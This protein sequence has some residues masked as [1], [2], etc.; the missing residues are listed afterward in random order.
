MAVPA[1]M[2]ALKPYLQHAKQTSKVDPLMSYH[3]EHISPARVLTSLTS[4]LHSGKYYAAT[5]GID[6]AP[7]QPDEK[8]FLLS[9][10]D[11]LDEE[12]K[13]LREQLG[14]PANKAPHVRQ[15]CDKIFDK[16]DAEDRAGNASK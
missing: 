3:C 11:E 9:I 16:A 12:K 4:K 13:V 14:D 5:L 2:K 7:S 6:K 1:S 15:F 8:A 10:L